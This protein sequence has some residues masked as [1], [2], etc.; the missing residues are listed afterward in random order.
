LLW[1]VL[2]SLWDSSADGDNASRVWKLWQFCAII[3]QPATQKNLSPRIVTPGR[4]ALPVFDLDRFKIIFDS[5]GHLIGDLL[6]QDVPERL[7]SCSHEADIF[8]RDIGASF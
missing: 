5:L 8:I 1:L 4:V 7:K 6:L 2:P 3:H